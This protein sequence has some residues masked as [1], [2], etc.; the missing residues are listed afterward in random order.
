MTHGGG[1]AGGWVKNKPSV[2]YYLNGPLLKPMA[3]NYQYLLIAILYAK[4]SSVSRPLLG[5]SIVKAKTRRNF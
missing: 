2:I 3:Q 5:Q 1:G 4:I